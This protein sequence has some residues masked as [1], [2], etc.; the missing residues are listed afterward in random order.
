VSRR[1]KANKTFQRKNT[2]PNKLML[3]QLTGHIIKPDYYECPVHGT[4]CGCPQRL[5]YFVA[6]KDIHPERNR[7]VIA[8]HDKEMLGLPAPQT[9]KPNGFDVERPLLIHKNEIERLLLFWYNDGETQRW[10]FERTIIMTGFK[11]RSLTYPNKVFAM[12]TY[13]HNKITWR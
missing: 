4:H 6:F 3:G 7:Q 5:P 8:W 1:K 2:G 11:Q 10:I 13:Q 12:H 9:F